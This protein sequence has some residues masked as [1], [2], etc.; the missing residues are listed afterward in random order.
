ME[1]FKGKYLR[2]RARNVVRK[3]ESVG[4]NLTGKSSKEAKVRT[5]GASRVEAQV[6]RE[7]AT[8]GHRIESPNPNGVAERWNSHFSRRAQSLIL[9]VT[10]L[11]SL[12]A[13][14]TRAENWPL[15]RGASQD[16]ISNEKDLPL[17][18]SETENVTWKLPLKGTASST[19]VIWGDRVFLTAQTEDQIE[20]VIAV[21]RNEAK[22]LWEREV[23]KGMTRT[24]AGAN[25]ASASPSTDGERVVAVFGTGDLVCFDNDGRQLWKHNLPQ[26]HGK[27]TVWWGYSNSPVIYGDLV[28]VTVINEGPSYLL[29]L[30]K[31]TGETKWKTARKTPATS[32]ACDAYATPIVYT[33]QGKSE[34]FI[35]GGTWGTAYDPKDGKLLWQADL[36][37]DRTILSPTYQDGVVYV[38]AGKRGAIYAVRSGGN[39]DVTQSHILW[40]Y[41]HSTPDVPSPLV[42]GDYLYVVNDTGVAMCLKK[43]D[44]SL[45]W[46]K[47][48]GGDFKASPVTSE[49]RIY[50]TNKDGET[51]VIEAGT[52]FKT[53]AVNQLGEGNDM[54]S[55]AISDGQIFQRS[56]SHLYCIGKKKK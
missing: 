33:A 49:G 7:A 51:T 48:I 8:L 39:G 10:A 37:G 13:L 47:R 26:E 32:E 21:E 42:L 23:G 50:L 43:S 30:D 53:L 38:T 44:G 5:P 56:Q 1:E 28:F 34:V 36:G 29:A 14:P 55:L 3:V 54:A 45:I 11:L 15:W 35:V 6:C 9:A 52:T 40:K 27:F 20:W 2:A 12:P 46:Q 17:H 31:K 22:I 25:M 24:R 41:P 16:G 19:P 4:I 18:W